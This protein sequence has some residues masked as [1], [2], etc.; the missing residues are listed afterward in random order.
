MLSLPRA[1]TVRV[2]C[3]A[4]ADSSAAADL[5]ADGAAAAR[6]I[7]EVAGISSPTLLLVLIGNTIIHVMYVTMF[8]T[9]SGC[10][11]VDAG[12]ARQPVCAASIAV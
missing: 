2:C 7:R 6:D 1:R 4:A 3:H 8:A 12:Q 9:C 10:H 11:R 5:C